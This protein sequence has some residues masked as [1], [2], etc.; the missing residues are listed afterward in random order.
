[1]FILLQEREK[2]S[3][4]SET[5]KQIVAELEIW[6]DNFSHDDNT[7]SLDEDRKLIP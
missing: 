2:E 4:N 1:M 5:W 7:L 6:R 3:V